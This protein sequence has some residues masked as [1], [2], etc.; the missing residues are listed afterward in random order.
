MTI[1]G[2]PSDNTLAVTLAEA[3]ERGAHVWIGSVSAMATMTPRQ[4]E[5]IV[6]ALREM[7]RVT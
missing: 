6:R 3:I 1:Q 4:K 7:A 5:L 2:A